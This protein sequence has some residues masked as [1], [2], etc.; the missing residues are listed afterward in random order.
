MDRVVHVI[1]D[2]G[3]HDGIRDLGGDGPGRADRRDARLR[4][5]A[6]GAGGSDARS[7][8]RGWRAAAGS[9]AGRR[10]GWVG[11]PA[12]QIRQRPTGRSSPAGPRPSPRCRDPRGRARPAVHPV[13]ARRQ[14]QARDGPGLLQLSRHLRRQGH[15]RRPNRGRVPLQRRRALPPGRR[16][17]ATP[18]GSGPLAGASIATPRTSPACTGPSR[19]PPASSRCAASRPATAGTSSGQLVPVPARL[20]TLV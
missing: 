7:A 4:R 12:R 6:G 17:S 19:A 9:G 14:G 13:R 8:G 1:S 15:R 20:R 18:T 2:P 3:D 5:G 11:R 10:L 16:P